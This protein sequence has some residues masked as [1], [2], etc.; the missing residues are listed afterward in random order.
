[1]SSF[2]QPRADEM[3]SEVAGKVKRYV[4]Q[5]L[6]IEHYG[7]QAAIKPAG[8]VVLRAVDKAASTKEEIVYDEIDIPASLIFK[9]ASLLKATRNVEYVSVSGN[10]QQSGSVSKSQE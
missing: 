9:L 1:M 10:D 6:T 4:H 2:N 5:P 3:V 7:I 8:R